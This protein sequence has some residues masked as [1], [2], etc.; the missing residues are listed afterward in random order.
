[1]MSCP[2]RAAP[3]ACL[4]TRSSSAT[5]AVDPGPVRHPGLNSIAISTADNLKSSRPGRHAWWPGTPDSLKLVIRKSQ[6]PKPACGRALIAGM[7]AVRQLD[8]YGSFYANRPGGST[9]LTA[10]ACAGRFAPYADRPD[11]V[12]RCPGPVGGP[13][14]VSVARFD[15]RTGRRYSGICGR[16][17]G[18]RRPVVF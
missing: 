11:E 10:T 16:D 18:S 5:A 13:G 7:S 4:G 17:S 9:K 3:A 6:S 15:G 8:R 2:P 1:M 12:G 14:G